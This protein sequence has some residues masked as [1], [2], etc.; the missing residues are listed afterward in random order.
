MQL[1][2]FSIGVA[3]AERTLKSFM[4]DKLYYHPAQKRTAELAD[5]LIAGLFAAYAQDPS[6][7]PGDWRAALPEGE[8]HRSRHIADFIAGMTDRYAIRAH[9]D[10]FGHAPRGAEQCLSGGGMGGGAV[11]MVLV[12]ATGLVGREIMA[13]SGDH[14]VSA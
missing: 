7:M 9:A 13:R 2:G 1:A 8:P 6:L 4:Y 3:E 11:H 14:P 12:G 5:A 10:I